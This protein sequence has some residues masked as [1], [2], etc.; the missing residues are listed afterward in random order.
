M[1]FNN[2]DFCII[3]ELVRPE[4]GGKLTILGF[5]GLAPHVEVVVGNPSQ[6]VQLSFVAGF[7][8]VTV[9]VAAGGYQSMITVS[10][11]NGSLI[12]QTPPTPLQASTS[13]RGVIASSFVLMPPHAWGRHTIR[14][15]VNTEQKLEALFNLRTATPAE[16]AQ[17]AGVPFIAPTGRPN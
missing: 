1:P 4:A 5:Y 8:P 9:P 17:I 2:F 15:K 11:P 13:L 7:P 14:V 6:P 10:K 12:F 16:T 3:C